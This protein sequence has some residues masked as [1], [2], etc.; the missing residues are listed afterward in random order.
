MAVLQSTT[1]GLNSGQ[2]GLSLGPPLDRW[3]ID[4]IRMLIPGN[5]QSYN[6]QHKFICIGIIRSETYNYAI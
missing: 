6:Q 5:H 2:E 1:K 3:T 4:T